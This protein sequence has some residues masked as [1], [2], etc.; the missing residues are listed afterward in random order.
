MGQRAC[1]RGW[2]L[3]RAR[4][5]WDDE[6]LPR[7]PPRS[8]SPQPA[9]V[10]MRL[11][12]GGARL[13]RAL[14]PGAR[15]G[16]APLS[17]YRCGFRR[18]SLAWHRPTPSVLAGLPLPDSGWSP[19]RTGHPK[20]NFSRMSRISG[21]WRGVLYGPS[22]GRGRSTARDYWAGCWCR[23]SDWPRGCSLPRAARSEDRSSFEA[24]WFG[25]PGRSPRC[26]TATRSTS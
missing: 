23:A 24:R 19:R 17:L 11:E 20:H 4:R 13:A 5:G 3:R 12:I 14:P 9:A 26:G 1:P 10:T 8:R 18:P 21:R 22:R 2:G 16:C 6:A 7:H 15:G 25:R